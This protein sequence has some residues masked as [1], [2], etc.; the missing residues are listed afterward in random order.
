MVYITCVLITSCI[1]KDVT[2]NCSKYVTYSYMFVVVM[3]VSTGEQN[4]ISNYSYILVKD[5]PLP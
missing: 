2:I 1:F 3:T 5:V 4:V